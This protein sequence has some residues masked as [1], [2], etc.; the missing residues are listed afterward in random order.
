MSRC[1]VL[2][3]IQRIPFRLR[4][5]NIQSLQ[6]PVR[7][8]FWALRSTAIRRFDQKAAEHKTLYFFMEKTGFG[9]G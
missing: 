6:D 8:G 2:F 9:A 3:K 1:S 5:I 7:A 4:R